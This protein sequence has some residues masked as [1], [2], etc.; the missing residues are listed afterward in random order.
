M[1]HARKKPILVE[2][3]G[4]LEHY[5][6]VITAHGPIFVDAGNY[7]VRDPNTGDTWPIKADIFA[8]TYDI[9][10]TPAPAPGRR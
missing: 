1:I 2:V 4:P 5:R 6:I 9:V 3:E 8:A 7:I 10:D